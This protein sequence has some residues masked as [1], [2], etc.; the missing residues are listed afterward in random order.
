MAELSTAA[1]V[2]GTAPSLNSNVVNQKTFTISGT[3]SAAVQTITTSATITGITA[4]QYLVNCSTGEIIY[5]EGIS[6]ADFTLC[7]RGADGSTAVAMATGQILRPV[8]AANLYNQMVREIIAMATVLNNADAVALRAFIAQESLRFQRSDGQ[9]NHS[10]IQNVGTNSHTTI[11]AFI[12][13]KAA[14]SGLASLDGS[15]LVVQNPANAAATAAASKIP[16][17]DAAGVIDSN[18]LCI[19]DLVLYSKFFN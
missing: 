15:S 16:L 1:F 7:T 12:A 6:G 5:I 18:Y 14:A 19:G 8:I 3:H 11:D 10:N 17:A 13:S 4:P 2:P 9:I